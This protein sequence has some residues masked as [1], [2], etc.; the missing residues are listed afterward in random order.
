MALP[1][2][3]LVQQGELGN[4][5]KHKLDATVAPINTDDGTKNWSYRSQWI[6]NNTDVYECLDN[7]QNNAVWKKLNA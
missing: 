3:I 1:K 2:T 4:V 5:I 6:V 7:K